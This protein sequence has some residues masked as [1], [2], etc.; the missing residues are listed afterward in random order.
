M[1]RRSATTST[2]VAAKTAEAADTVMAWL[3]TQPRAANGRFPGVTA[4]A[5]DP[6]VAARA[7]AVHAQ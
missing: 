5:A 6:M 4:L 7:D 2:G 1:T 3:Q